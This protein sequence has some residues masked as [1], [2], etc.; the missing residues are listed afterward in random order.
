VSDTFVW[1]PQFAV[2]F[3]QIDKEHE[4]SFTIINAVQAAVHRRAGAAVVQDLLRAVEKQLAAHFRDEE[5]LLRELGYP[6]I[7]I[8]EREHALL[9]GA[10]SELVL[11]VADS[12]AGPTRATDVLRSFLL[13]H[14]LGTD[15]RAL[16]W[17][18]Q[19]SAPASRR[20]PTRDAA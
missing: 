1:K 20:A 2:G 9:A 17:A 18:A 14:V 16:S 3:E 15:K 8:M 6:Q 13:D 4:E 7:S 19:H 5:H 11:T 12:V 10:I